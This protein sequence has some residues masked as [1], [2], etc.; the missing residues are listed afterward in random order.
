[1]KKTS[2]SK[3]A[4]VSTLVILSG[5]SAFAA[6]NITTFTP[7][8]PIKAAEVNANFSS[9]KTA[10][11]GLQ[12]PGGIVGTQLASGGFDGAVLKL[13]GSNLSWATDLQGTGGG[14]GTNF[15]ADGS[16]LTLNG[17]TFSIKDGG[18]TSNKLANN[19]VTSS[20]ISLP[21]TLTGSS[22][23]TLT[24]NNS[25]GI[26]IVGSSNS[27]RGVEGN[28]SSSTGVFGK[29]DS[30]RG[31]EGVSSSGIGV[32]GISDNRGV[33]GTQGVI[34]C[35]GAYAVGGCATSNIGVFGKSDT[36]RAV[37]GISPSGIGVI[38]ISDARGVI[39][40]QGEISCPG[41]YAVGGCATSNRGVFGSSVSGTGVVGTS[42]TGSSGSFVGGGGGS[43]L[44]FY[45]GGAGWN[46]SSD[47]NKKK[48]FKAVNARTVLEALNKMPVTTWTMKGD[49]N[50]IPHIGP[51]AQDF[52][53][54]FG[55]GES[56][57]TINTAD[58]QGVAMAAI[59]GLYGVV[60]E[61]DTK[62]VALESRIVS[63]EAR[64]EKL[65]SA[66]NTH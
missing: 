5:L 47:R 63:L 66:I 62:I 28:S 30:A 35:P 15:N 37:Q 65:E 23:T 40:T 46:C 52:K 2:L 54:A 49:R 45:N 21:L 16:S 64:L 27:S 31:V 1:M 61:R 3:R 12:A 36:S 29:S 17:T 48:N 51:V 6:V 32:I 25:G 60:K 20:K 33:I 7:G 41:A 43:G 11:E 56:D 58:A 22:G 34:S 42:V 39:G 18:V 26:G 13:S 14:G 55:V 57:L 10:L 9:L 44:C 59:K 8:T 50:A 53:S 38:G 19:S 24:V 4:L